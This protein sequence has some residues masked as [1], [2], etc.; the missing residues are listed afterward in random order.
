MALGRAA[1]R[2]DG[3]LPRMMSITRA[4]APRNDQQLA[5]WKV[6]AALGTI[7]GIASFQHSLLPR[8]SKQQAIVTAAALALGYG[9]GV[10]ANAI[11]NKVDEKTGLDAVG[12]RLA[13][14]GAGAAGVLGAT[15]AIRGV[16]P[17]LAFDALRTGAGV[18]GAGAV[19]GTALIGE[20]ALVDR[21]EDK[22]PGGA[23]AAHAA[24][25]GAAALGVGA[26]VLGRARASAVS[27]EAE[28]AYLASTREGVPTSGAVFDP[29]RFATLTQQRRAMT[30]VSGVSAGTLLPDTE[31]SAHGLKFLN[32]ATPA[33]EIS[34]VMG[35]DVSAVKDPIRVY[36]GMHHAETR[37][38]L[39]QKIF[40]EALAKGA[41]DRK[42]VI[43]YVPSGSGHVNPMPVA[44]AEY[45]T[46]GDIAS[47]GMQY[48][49]K[50][51]IQSVHKVG[52]GTELFDEVLKRFSAH[53]K[54]L[55]GDARPRLSAYGESLGAW[56]MQDA[57]L[58]TGPQGIA[59]RGLDQIVNVGSPRFSKLRS[60]AI[61][62]AG[63]ALD[64][65]GTMFEFNDLS[66]LQALPA[67]QRVGVKAFLLTH[68]NDPVN[69]FSP[70]M[71][72]QRPEWL[73]NV[74]HATGVPRRL[75]WMPGV[76]G[77]QGVMDTVNGT[78]P[79]AGILAKTG[80]DYRA[81]MAPVMAEVLRTP[82][83]KVQMAGIN[84]A[85]M[86]LELAR[87]RMPQPTPRL[88]G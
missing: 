52:I 66:G 4:D 68:H 62:K 15:L 1:Q 24:I 23:P 26:V 59:S 30:T 9:A 34:R 20:Q 85:L 21:F 37:V 45:A 73:G 12:S 61:G 74:E 29:D 19:V 55:P 87:V 58:A 14:A 18:L 10:A 81:D 36:G 80:H 54:T 16:K 2:D 11:A 28:R 40:D 88:V 77:V 76:T 43:L 47:I 25:L 38:E 78:N 72:I 5:G 83:T 64:R 82:T 39:A 75:K 65:S 79:M 13:V 3:E 69:K 56:S 17:S 51:S 8:S 7:A 60:D 44:A 86:Q 41:F 46:L 22:V 27:V 35:T 33:T 70:T 67:E 31:L 53:I 50:P 6:G 57:F 48:N 84:D 49:N 32:E 63:H 42:H 71:F